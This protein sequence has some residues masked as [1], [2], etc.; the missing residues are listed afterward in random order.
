MEIANT[1][2]PFA[3]MQGVAQYR[4]ANAGECGARPGSA[5]S[6]AT[7]GSLPFALEPTSETEF[8]GMVYADGM[9]DEDY[10]GQGACRWELA[11]V[12]VL[13]RTTETAGATVFIPH[14]APESLMADKVETTYFWRGEFQRVRAVDRADFGFSR[15]GDFRYE[16]RHDL[17]SITLMAR[18]L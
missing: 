2:E 8:E 15:P 3:S 1:P 10:F 16:L 14:L 9:Q 5:G 13:L 6:A 17:F 11:D 4:I 7:T 12:R 18:R